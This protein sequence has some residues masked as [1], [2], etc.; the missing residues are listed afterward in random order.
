VLTAL[1]LL[2]PLGVLIALKTRDVSG[3]LGRAG[4]AAK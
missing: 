1:G 4:G 3:Y 2:F